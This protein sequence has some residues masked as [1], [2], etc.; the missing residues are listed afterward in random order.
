MNKQETRIDQIGNFLSFSR[1][2][3][4]ITPG[5]SRACPNAP[6]HT[7]T[8]LSGARGLTPEGVMMFVKWKMR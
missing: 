3:L 1:I 4:K 6:E 5:N 8:G 2:G 7:R